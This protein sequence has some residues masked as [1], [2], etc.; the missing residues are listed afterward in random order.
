MNP[1]TRKMI[2]W[3]L[4]ILLLGLALLSFQIL[5]TANLLKSTLLTPQC[6]STN[7][8]SIRSSLPAL[9]YAWSNPSNL[10]NY[11]NATCLQ[12]QAAYENYRTGGVFNYTTTIS[13]IR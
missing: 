2:V 11:L 5:H 4:L 6:N 9:E 12:Y 13:T 7:A 10:T 3:S 8:N 1:K